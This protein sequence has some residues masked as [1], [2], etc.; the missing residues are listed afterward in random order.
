MSKTMKYD[1]FTVRYEG[2][3][4]VVAFNEVAGIDVFSVD[5]ANGTTQY[6]LERSGCGTIAGFE[7][8]VAFAR[9]CYR[10]E[11]NTFTG[12]VSGRFEWDPDDGSVSILINGKIVGWAFE[13]DPEDAPEG[14]SPEIMAAARKWAGWS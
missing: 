1:I 7:R 9:E 4:V 11:N 12:E 2:H 3:G 6:L 10:E 13:D 14:V 8:V 5:V